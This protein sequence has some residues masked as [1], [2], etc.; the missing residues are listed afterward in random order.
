LQGE[1]S[2]GYKA[3]DLQ[4]TVQV[5]HAI[6]HMTPRIAAG[7]SLV[8]HRA[9]L[10]AGFAFG[11]L[12]RGGAVNHC[13]VPGASRRLAAEDERLHELISALQDH[14]ADYS[15]ADVRRLPQVCRVRSMVSPCPI[16]WLFGLPDVTIRA[17]P[18]N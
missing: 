5:G 15:D 1:L 11:R 9:A 16:L 3:F 13:V 8:H 14:G 10:Q 18:S 12:S 7:F 17:V 2:S 6:H 4:S